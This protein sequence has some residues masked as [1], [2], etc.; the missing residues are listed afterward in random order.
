[1]E[2]YDP[3]DLARHGDVLIPASK[4][5]R[6]EFARDRD[7]ILYTCAFRAL[8]G[9][10]QVVAAGELGNFH[11]RL[12]HSL[13]VAQLGRVIAGRLARDYAPYGPDPDLVEAACLAHDIGHPPFGHAGESA[14]SDTI[15]KLSKNNQDQAAD[16]FEGNAQNLRILTY[17]A[18]DRPADVP[19]LHLTRGTLR[20]VT[21]Y[22]WQREHQPSEKFKGKWCFYDSH[23][24]DLTW[25]LNGR[26][27]GAE[28]PIEEQIM[29][30]CDDVTYACHDM[31]DFYTHGMIPLDRLLDFRSAEH[32]TPGEEPVELAKF[33]DF[34]QG[35]WRPE[36][37][38]GAFD[39]SQ[40]VRSFRG[41]RNL[42]TDIREPYEPGWR[43]EEKVRE[44]I[45]NLIS[46]FADGVSAG[47]TKARSYE[48]ALKVDEEQRF[49]CTLLK[50]LIWF[51]VI[52][53]PQLAGQQQGQRKIVEELLEWHFKNPDLLPQDLRRKDYRGSKLRAACDY[54]ASLTEAHAYALHR[55]LSGAN[56]GLITDLV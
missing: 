15:D 24:R 16:G 3:S 2:P 43:M 8:A 17:L 10:T 45:T 6:S 34:A 19:G 25:M 14:L 5:G 12:T 55:R 33:L 22:P 20:A 31:E 32:L 51:Y 53:R 50:K 38:G 9:K 46:Y 35:D 41:I 36:K 56:F 26:N 54:V 52:R 28:F 11:T 40:A 47:G 4:S 48:G 42:L 7:R 37:D 44:S 18:V 49:T 27:G 39:R 23:D 30:W 13:K 29:D 21:K 1:M